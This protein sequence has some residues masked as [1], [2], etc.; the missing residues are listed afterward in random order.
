M[1]SWMGNEVWPGVAYEGAVVKYVGG[2]TAA[3]QRTPQKSVNKVKLLFCRQ[4]RERRPRR[5][6]VEIGL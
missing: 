5:N 6:E 2:V 4:L 1:R 3:L